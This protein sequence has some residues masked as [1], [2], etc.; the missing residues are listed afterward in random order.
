M[1]RWSGCGSSTPSHSLPTC[2]SWSRWVGSGWGVGFRPA[3]QF[4]HELYDVVEWLRQQ[5]PHTLIAKL[6]ELVKV[7]SVCDGSGFKA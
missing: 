6:R 3:S 4:L 2:G 1:M 5:H 7:L